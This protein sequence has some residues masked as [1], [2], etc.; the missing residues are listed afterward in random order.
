ML[1]KIP[2]RSLEYITFL[3]A[4]TQHLSNRIFNSCR[5]IKLGKA[6]YPADPIIGCNFGTLFTISADGKSLEKTH[7]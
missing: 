6:F 5:R 1:F 3:K 7:Q 2:K 4:K